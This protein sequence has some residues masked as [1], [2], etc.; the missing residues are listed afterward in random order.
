MN[1]AVWSESLQFLPEWINAIC[2]DLPG[3]G[4]S[5]SVSAA[6]LDDYVEHVA[7][8][9]RQP[10]LMVGWSLGGLVTLQLAQRY[11]EKVSGLFQV[12]TN[13]KFVQSDNWQA[14]VEMN[15]FEQFA[16]S[17][18]KD[19]N[20]TVRRFLA[21]QVR[22]T[23]A[24]MQ[25]VRELQQSTNERGLPGLDVLMQGLDILSSA[26]LT[27]ELSQCQCPVTWLLGDKDAMVP[28]EVAES[29]KSLLPGVDINIIQ[30]AGHAPFVSHPEVFSKLLVQT[31]ERLV[32]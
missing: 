32:K 10:S 26:D 14:G 5:S 21:L 24:S 4:E 7:S 19:I 11:P 2:L 17:L 13:P 18:N 28:V 22:G 1:S 8:C 23:S 12:A 31:A 9:V 25:T 16:E 30:G 27:T 29:I 3:Y 15:V 20:A 6:S